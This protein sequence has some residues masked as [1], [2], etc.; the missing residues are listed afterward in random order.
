MNYDFWN[1]QKSIFGKCWVNCKEMPGKMKIMY[2]NLYKLTLSHLLV[3][4]F[5]QWIQNQLISSGPILES[6]GMRAI[7][8]K[9]GK[10]KNLEGQKRAKYLKIWAKIYK[11]SKYIEKRRVIVCDNRTQWTARKGPDHEHFPDTLEKNTHFPKF[12][13]LFS[14]S[15]IHI[16]EEAICS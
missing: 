5:W 10:K 7:F 6:K 8:Q 11:I 1:W 12:T 13:L 3:D 15:Y 9:K 4:G 16:N 14:I 2:L